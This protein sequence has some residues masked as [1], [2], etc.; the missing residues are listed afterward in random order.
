MQPITS[1]QN[2]LIKDVKKLELKKNRKKNHEYLI[3]GVHL[4]EEA[5]KNGVSI[6]RAF[7]T[8]KYTNHRL[9]K[10]YYDNVYEITEELSEYISD[11]QT[12]QGIFAVADITDDEKTI[13]YKGKWILLD[14]VQDPGN[15]GTIVRTADAAGFSGVILGDNTADLYQGK[16]QRAMQGSQFHINT[17]NI[18]SA[19]AITGFANAGVSVWATE[20]NKASKPVTELKNPEDVLVVVGNEANGLKADIL[21]MA[22]EQVF[23]PIIGKAESLN[24]AIAASIMMYKLGLD[25]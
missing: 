9:V 13:D 19:K 11:T 1:K 5:L 3:E 15:V 23:I 8:D 2:D 20:V 21:Q 18:P 6:R 17:F 14:N 22:D 25:L 10:E 4:V 16:V 12:P 24:V 7:V